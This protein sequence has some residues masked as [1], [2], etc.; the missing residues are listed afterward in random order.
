MKKNSDPFHSGHNGIPSVT[1][2]SLLTRLSLQES[3]K[4]EL[5][6]ELQNEFQTSN[7]LLPISIF[8]NGKLGT[9]EVIVKFLRE[10]HQMSLI[11][12]APFLGR[13]PQAL[14]VTYHQAKKKMPERLIPKD[15]PFFIPVLIFQRSQLS[16]L[17]TF[18]CYLKETYPLTNHQIAVM[19]NRNDRTI[20]TTYA[21]AKK[22][23]GGR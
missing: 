18:V 17:E 20:W 12:I 10:N 1:A 6:K 9:L 8:L 23:R 5:F 11:K 3:E 7:P 16:I 4:K 13:S 21:N 2:P 15:S 19:L 22:K 14:A